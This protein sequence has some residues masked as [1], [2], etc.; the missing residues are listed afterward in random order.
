MRS[1]S[2]ASI[3]VIAEG[4]AE[5]LE[6]TAHFREG[7]KVKSLGLPRGTVVGAIVRGDEVVVPDGDSAVRRGDHVILFTLPDN[8]AAVE[9]V[10]RSEQE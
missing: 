10:F 9:Q 4:R 7:R 8:V 3:A 1:R 6:L 5:V 2:L